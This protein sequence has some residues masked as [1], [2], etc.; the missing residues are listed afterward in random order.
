MHALRF[1]RTRTETLEII[2]VGKV[3]HRTRYAALL[4]VVAISS[5]RFA[6]Q[7]IIVIIILVNRN[8]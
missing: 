1:E 2:V 6:E 4:C 5:E 8:H 7:H 3:A